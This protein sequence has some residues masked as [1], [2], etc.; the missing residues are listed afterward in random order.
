MP[1]TY[2]HSPEN[3]TSLLDQLASEGIAHSRDE[4]IRAAKSS[5]PHS[6][7]PPSRHPLAIVFPTSTQ[8]TSKILAACHA[9]RIATTSF[10]GGTSLPGAL[11]ALHTGVCISFERMA[12]LLSLQKEDMHITVQPGLNWVDLNER[13]KPDG[14]FFPV[15]PSPKAC[16]GGM[17]AMSCSGTNAYRYG[18]V[19]PQVVNLTC[20][21]ADGRVVKTR[22]RP[23]KSSAG[24]DLASLVVGSE[25]TLALVTEAVFKVVRLP[26]FLHVGTA[27]FKG[28]QAGVDVVMR[29][30]E[31]GIR[32]EALE[33]ADAEQMR[34]TNFSGLAQIKFDDVPTLFF[35]VA[36]ETKGEI[37]GRLQTLRKVLADLGAYNVEITDD[38]KRSEMIWQV[39]KCMGSAL[40]A[41]KK[42]ESDLWLHSDCAVPVSN[43]AKL[44]EGSQELVRVAN[45][46]RRASATKGS[47]GHLEFQ[48]WFCANVG[49]VGDGNVHT[50]IVCP[51]ADQ[52]AAEEFLRDVARLALKLEGTVT[53]E[54]GVGM[55]LRSALVEEVGVEG[56]SVMR[57]VKRALDPH[58][59]L[60]PDKVIWWDEEEEKKSILKA[61][62]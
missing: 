33:L 41:M 21:L 7:A 38:S 1:P 42:Q 25:G 50:S 20:V 11:T 45:E 43:L 12:K 53:G 54:H 8:Q 23:V 39:R 60:N 46:K 49:H 18:T 9:R 15:D 28:F 32:L 19:R 58:G 4:T 56:T 3:I 36:G 14:L 57:A 26:K 44:V 17:I 2:N 13:L 55:E 29:L 35:K 47:D 52:H 62:L 10:S 22:R 6:P 31:E 59:I 48:E 24:Y 61:N 5:T 51:A 16:I 27:A 30:Q 37:D 40:I 34:C